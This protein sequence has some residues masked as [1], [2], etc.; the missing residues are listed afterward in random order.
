MDKSS[1]VKKAIR[2][3]MFLKMARLVIEPSVDLILDLLSSVQP[4]MLQALQDI[5]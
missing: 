3:T 1:M 5:P 4:L 2:Q